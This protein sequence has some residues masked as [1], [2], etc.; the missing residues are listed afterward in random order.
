MEGRE[1]AGQPPALTG[2]G[3]LLIPQGEACYNDACMSVLIGRGAAGAYVLPEAALAGLDLTQPI[4]L[5]DLPL[6]H[7]RAP[8]RAGG[9]ALRRTL[10][11]PERQRLTGGVDYVILTGKPFYLSKAGALEDALLTHPDLRSMRE[12]ELLRLAM[13]PMMPGR[14][15]LSEMRFDVL[16]L[17]RSG[18]GDPA[19]PRKLAVGAKHVGRG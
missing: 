14:L 1:V 9:E 5:A 2:R 13:G 4:L 16:D 18:A 7:W 17:C 11:M 19:G 15:S 12:G 3:V 10:S 8:G 6:Q